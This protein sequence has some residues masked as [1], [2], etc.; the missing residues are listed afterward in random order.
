MWAAGHEDGV[1][2]NAAE[3]VVDLLI[4]RGAEID[5]SDDRGR[6]ALMMAAELGHA[7]VAAMLIGRGADRTIRD[8]SGKSALDLAANDSVRQALAAR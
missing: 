1:G 5:A 7:E 2:A 4:S 6:T 8:N 3:S